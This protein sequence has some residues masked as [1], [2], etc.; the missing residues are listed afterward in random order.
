MSKESFIPPELKEKFKAYDPEIQDFITA[1]YAEITKLQKKNIKLQAE[2][3]SLN[4]RIAVLEKENLQYRQHIEP[5]ASE[6]SEA[7]KR[8]A[9]RIPKSEDE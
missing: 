7:L 4:S 8:L 6:A 5:S 1:L 9:G 3:V 2:N